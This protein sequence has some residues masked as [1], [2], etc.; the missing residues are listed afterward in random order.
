MADITSYPFPSV[1]SMAGDDGQN[2]VGIKRYSDSGDVYWDFSGAQYDEFHFSLHPQTDPYTRPLIIDLAQYDNGTELQ[3][4]YFTETHIESSPG[5]VRVYGQTKL[6]DSRT[7]EELPLS[8]GTGNAIDADRAFNMTVRLH[9]NT[10]QAVAA[11]E[12]YPVR[13]YYSTTSYTKV[14]TSTTHVGDPAQ[15]MYGFGTLV[16]TNNEN[17][18][19]SYPIEKLAGKVK[20]SDLPQQYYSWGSID[21]WIITSDEDLN[22]GID[23]LVGAGNGKNPVKDPVSPSDK[24]FENDTSGTGGG[25]GKYTINGDKTGK[26]GLPS[27]NV[28]A[29]GF[30]AMYNPTL[31]N[32]QALGAK[33][34]SDDFVD[35]FL[36]LWNDPMEAIISLGL[37]P[38]SPSSSGST[39]CQ[40]GNYDTEISMPRVTSQYE[41]LSCGSVYIDEYWGNALDYGPY[42]DAEIYLPFVGMR[43]LDIDDIMGKTVSVDYNI[44]LLGGEAIAYITV[45]DRVLYDFRCN[46]M[47]AIPISSSSYASL[48]SSILGAIT[49]VGVGAVAGG[50]VGA[51]AGGLTSAANIITSKHSSIERGGEC[52]P[53]GGVLGILTP[54]ILLHRPIQ[55]LPANFGHFKGYP[56]NVTRT[57]SGIS[58]YTE[59]E[60]IHLDGISATDAEKEEIY[61]LLKAGVIL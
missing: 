34:W 32:L 20:T 4:E 45:N 26:P 60:Y 13:Y 46:V 56:S 52:S 49:S 50:G 3:L 12:S 19:P 59:I 27:S 33:L 31:A 58:G 23:D 10:P 47:T 53:N 21:N 57:L 6:V 5:Y 28:L 8:T 61:A 24:P 40:I 55:S 42:T 17:G 2:L 43:H 30:I 41:S 18:I 7:Q 37:V 9:A 39:V 44:D 25:K 38:F 11:F 51:A 36:K 35:N 29:S 1:M 54:Y 14:G 15:S 16:T 22:Q 48:Y